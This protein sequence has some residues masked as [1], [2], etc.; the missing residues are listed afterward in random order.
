MYPVDDLDKVIEIDDFPPH[1]IGAPLPVVICN[2]RDLFVLYYIQEP[3]DPEIFKNPNF[4]PKVMDYDDPSPIAIIK[5]HAY[6]HMFG[7]PDE[8]T[9]VGHPL[10]ERGLESDSIFEV[11]NSS[12]IRQSVRM[13]MKYD[14]IH[15]HEQ[16]NYEEFIS[17]MKHYIFAFHDST[18][19]CIAGDYEIKI[20]KGPIFSAAKDMVELL[21]KK[22]EES[23]E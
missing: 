14:R 10:S 15:E 2:D 11:R 18:F 16:H 1:S 21:F 23:D 12:W 7:N 5:F 19:E 22:D 4:V 9:L 8:E 17:S 13:R 6:V 20:Q 3:F